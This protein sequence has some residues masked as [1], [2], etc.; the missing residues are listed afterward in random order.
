LLDI[1]P[2]PQSMEQETLLN[3]YKDVQL[4]ASVPLYRNAALLELKFH[5]EGIDIFYG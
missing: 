5:Q 3:F 2:T 4:N 1:Q